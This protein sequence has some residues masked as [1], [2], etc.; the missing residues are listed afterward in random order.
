MSANADVLSI[1]IWSTLYLYRYLDGTV[2]SRLTQAIITSLLERQLKTVTDISRVM[3]PPEH[4][5]QHKSG[6]IRVSDK[7][8]GHR[9]LKQSC[10][11]T[12]WS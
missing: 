11:A 9:H 1:N 6:L 4:K 3:M 10:E 8:I 2:L 7:I 12:H 5:F